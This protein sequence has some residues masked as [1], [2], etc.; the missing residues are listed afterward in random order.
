MICCQAKMIANRL[1]ELR[2]KAGWSQQKLAEKSGLSYNT[3]TKIEQGAATKPTIQT[4]IRIADAFG[5]S[6]D[7]LIGRK[8]D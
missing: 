7:E 8:I 6:L 1:K 4:I 5:V 2:K 3:I